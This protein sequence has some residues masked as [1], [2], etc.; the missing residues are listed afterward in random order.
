MNLVKSPAEHP[1]THSTQVI[2]QRVWKV[3]P[4][5]FFGISVL[6]NPLDGSLIIVSRQ[7]PTPG[8]V[9]D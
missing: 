2:Q 9:P 8:V 6:E 1:V 4:G 5:T 7:T 3:N